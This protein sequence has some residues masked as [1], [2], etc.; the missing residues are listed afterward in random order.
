MI[1]DRL[2]RARTVSGAERPGNRA[3]ISNNTGISARVAREDAQTY[4]P[5]VW[6]LPAASGCGPAHLFARQHARRRR[7]G[8]DA[9]RVPI[10]REAA[11]SPGLAGVASAAASVSSRSMLP[12]TPVGAGPEKCVLG[13]LGACNRVAPRYNAAINRCR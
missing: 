4:W 5:N 8:R 7:L 9:R 2:C 1:G 6:S 12:Y 11:S 13:G 10:T 3:R